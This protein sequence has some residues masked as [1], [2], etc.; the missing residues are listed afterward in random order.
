M[1]EFTELYC[2]EC[3]GQ[4]VEE[5]TEHAL[6]SALAY[7]LDQD[8]LISPDEFEEIYNHYYTEG[9]NKYHREY[10]FALYDANKDHVLSLAEY[11]VF[12]CAELSGDVI[13]IGDCTVWAE[14][15]FHAYDSDHD[16]QLNVDEFSNLHSIFCPCSK[17]VEELWAEYD[18]N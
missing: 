17:T 13:S 2:K 12:Y 6:D 9:G 15:L 10:L 5:C 1:E 3:S 11:A 4:E 16:D 7:D 8:N 18:T 14:G